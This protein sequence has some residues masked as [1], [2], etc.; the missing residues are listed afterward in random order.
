[1]LKVLTNEHYKRGKLENGLTEYPDLFQECVD[2]INGMRSVPYFLHI[3][4]TS[5]TIGLGN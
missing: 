1:M 4:F 5:K 2:V 3:Y